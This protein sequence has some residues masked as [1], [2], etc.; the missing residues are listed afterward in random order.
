MAK[1]RPPP[2]HWPHPVCISPNL[3]RPGNDNT[4]KRQKRLMPLKRQSAVWNSS[5][6]TATN[7]DDG[8]TVGGKT[9]INSFPPFSVQIPANLCNA[10]TTTI[11][12]GPSAD[13]QSLRPVFFWHERKRCRTVNRCPPQS[14]PCCPLRC[15]PMFVFSHFFLLFL[16]L[17][18]LH[19]PPPS[20]FVCISSAV[21]PSP[22]RCPPPMNNNNNNN[23][24][25]LLNHR[26]WPS[27]PFPLLPC[28]CVH[29]LAFGAHPTRQTSLPVPQLQRKPLHS[30]RHSSPIPWIFST[31]IER[32]VPIH[33]CF[34]LLLQPMK[35]A[36]TIPQQ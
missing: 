12:R 17:L 24:S 3:C 36:T 22:S 5:V 26:R 29:R 25:F 32:L 7:A 9:A 13:R 30:R 18:L 14:A 10:N 31:R 33:R 27:R 8:N 6:S 15:L 1:C 2:F 23:S 20:N 21:P 19:S 35:M 16:L 11:V 28:H 4:S 34:R